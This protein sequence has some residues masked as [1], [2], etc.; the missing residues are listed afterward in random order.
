MSTDDFL[1][2][3]AE[4]LQQV[5]PVGDLDRVRCSLAGA[6]GVA[7]ASV[8]ADD[9]NARVV[10]QP[11]GEGVGGAVGQNVDRPA[12]VH[13]EQHRRVSVPTAAG[14]VVDAQHR[15]RHRRR[16][17]HPA[18]HPDQRG[19]GHRHGK[20]LR[21]PAARSAAQRRRDGLQITCREDR[22]AGMPS[23]QP[24]HLLDE[25]L[26]SAFGVHAG[27]SADRQRDQH[28]VATQP[29]IGQP[30]Q[31][32]TVH[33]GRPSAADPARRPHRLRRR[34]DP[35]RDAPNHHRF[36]P[37]ACQVRQQR[38]NDLHLGTQPELPASATHKM[39]ARARFHAPTTLRDVD[40]CTLWRTCL[41]IQSCTPHWLR[42]RTT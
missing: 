42:R 9:L 18:D 31:I 17:G 15:R 24:R 22:V 2:G 39:C 35:D 34:V 5:P 37:Q 21:Q 26:P 36:Q 23:G 28:L 30:P 6:L 40:L 32:A 7:A 4:V 1:D 12:G 29:D 20:P 38:R 33:R 16:V 19:A 27:E 14:E 8:A 11:G 25:R 13:V 10:A 3:V 41:R